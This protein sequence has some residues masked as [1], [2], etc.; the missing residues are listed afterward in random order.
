M[1]C[2]MRN[3][4]CFMEWVGAGGAPSHFLKQGW[5]ILMLPVGNRRRLWVNPCICYCSPPRR[6]YGLQWRHRRVL[7]VGSF[8]TL[9]IQQKLL[10]SFLQAYGGSEGGGDGNV[11]KFSNRPETR[12]FYL[13]RWNFMWGSRITQNFNLVGAILQ[14]LQWFKEWLDLGL[15]AQMT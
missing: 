10:K 6:S 12:N 15:Q 4:H 14:V 2:P 1:F 9:S 5:L 11:I 7:T 8:F 3:Q 13:H